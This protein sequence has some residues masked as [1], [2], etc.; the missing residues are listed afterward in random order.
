YLVC[1]YVPGGSLATHIDGT[2]WAA[3]RAAR[4]VATLA[5]AVAAAHAAGVVHRDIK[6]SNVLLAADGTPKVADFGVAKRLGADTLTR[7]GAVLGT[8]SYMAPEQA[9]GGKE[10]TAAADVYG[11]GAVLYELLTGRPP[12]A[13]ANFFDT[14]DQVRTRDPVTPRAL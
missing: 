8:P 10:V 14:L 7:T 6:P 13:G 5:R 1:E 4:L 3:D 9:G 11:L 12:F 2:P